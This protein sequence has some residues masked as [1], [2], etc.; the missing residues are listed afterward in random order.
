MYLHHTERPAQ[1]IREMARILKP[2]GALVITDLD[3]HSFE[4]LRA[5][6]H[7]RWMGFRRD[8]VR[9]WFEQAGLQNVRVDCAG[10]QCCA[11]SACG[12]ES[13]SISI[14]MASGTKQ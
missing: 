9:R 10:E 2:G 6:Q 8:D 5:E 14:F 11:S 12:C 13:A 4:F 3:E 1:A 7:D